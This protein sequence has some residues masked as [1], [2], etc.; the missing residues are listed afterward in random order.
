MFVHKSREYTSD[1]PFGQN[2]VASPKM[3]IVQTCLKLDKQIA[4]YYANL[5]WRG[6][7]AEKYE[8]FFFLFWKITYPTYTE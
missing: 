7:P 6:S 4:D 8:N 2:S 5:Y 1:T 3:A